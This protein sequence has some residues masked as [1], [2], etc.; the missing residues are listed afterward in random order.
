M[1]TRNFPASSFSN[2]LK[3]VNLSVALIGG[4]A[5][6]AP[7]LGT[8]DPKATFFSQPVRTGTGI[9]TIT[10][11]DAYPALA[12]C[13]LEY[14]L[15][16]PSATSNA[17]LAPLP[18]QNANNTWTFTINTFTAGAAADMLTTSTVYFSC[19]MQNTGDPYAG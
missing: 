13:N 7:T 4:G 12:T 15:V 6:N 19:C 5:G 1:A 17:M 3:G 9:Y 10:T 18:V 11:L 16:L 2:I 8:G 14:A